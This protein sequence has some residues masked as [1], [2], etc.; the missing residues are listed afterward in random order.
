M[1]YKDWRTWWKA[2]EPIIREAL[3]D[4]GYPVDADKLLPPPNKPET[5]VC[6]KSRVWFLS[7]RTRHGDELSF[8]AKCDE[9]DRFREEWKA[10]EEL[11]D[12][13]SPIEA[14]LPVSGNKPKHNVIVYQ[15]VAEQVLTG[16]VWTLKRLLKEQLA[17]NLDNC[18]QA[19]EDTL[20]P[21]RLF[22]TSEP[23]SARL[24]DHLGRG[25]W[26]AIF[27]AVQ[28]KLKQVENRANPQWLSGFQRSLPDP[29][30][31]APDFLN[32]RLGRV[33]HSRI[34]GDLNLTN[35]LI[36]LN[37]WFGPEKVFLIDLANSQRDAVTALD[38]ARLECEFWHEIFAQLGGE[39]ISVAER[40]NV[41]VAIR[42]CLDGRTCTLESSLPKAG[43]N[44]L[45]WVKKIR[46]EAYRT[47][48]GNQPDY[49]MADYMTALYLTHLRCL[50]FE[51][52]QESE[53]KQRIATLGAALALEYLLAL[54]KGGNP[55]IPVAS[56][57][58][59]ILTY[60]ED[61]IYIPQREWNANSCPPG[62]LLQ[63]NYVIVPFHG[64]EKAL[65]DLTVWAQSVSPISVRLYTG[66][67]GIGKTRLAIEICK[68]L[69]TMGY[70]AGFLRHIKKDLLI[71]TFPNNQNL[72]FVIDYAESNR[73]IVIQILAMLGSMGRD[74]VRIMLLARSAGQWWKNLRAE[75]DGVGD[76]IAS[77]A[78]Q[79]IPL[80]PLALTADEC[81]ASYWMA[82]KAFAEK[83]GQSLPK[84]EPDFNENYFEL[85]LLLHMRALAA[86][87]GV[88]V[89]GEDGI[90][91]YVLNRERRFWKKLLLDK[92][93]N[94]VLHQGLER[95]MAM[96]TLGGGVENKRE[97]LD[98]L[99]RIP[100]FA[101]EKRSVL[102]AV[103]EL[104]HASYPG[105]K[106]IE[107]I[108]P[109]LLGEHLFSTAL[110]DDA[111]E[112]FDLMLGEKGKN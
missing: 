28:N 25:T 99:R 62:A 13:K 87:E 11:R 60:N 5:G 93:L 20:K 34:H 22:Y 112:I 16:H 9:P 38:L 105:E 6:G 97:A 31:H 24:T 43:Q 80:K 98:V 82:A 18:L 71:Q 76:L 65:D 81:R 48:A 47:L 91:E 44:V 69:S 77:P 41:F 83:L 56:V 32:E 45:S 14:M 70:C 89:E 86:V 39:R 101:D 26:T 2:D 53:M 63:A 50:A 88:I 52:V 64:R 17:D 55:L 95:A 100:F 54:R 111:G 84:E 94:P 4:M 106:W 78:T 12:L 36:G 59:P 67:G 37:G 58:S 85:V 110:K 19:L 21:L 103:A 61:E 102:E 51:S 7:M 68:R 46:E 96:F 35:V 23:G 10:I 1:E 57:T 8:I 79:W 30:R 74:C 3:I 49:H 73:D 33:L 42:D 27:P 75:S 66:R 109:D 15:N 107:P 92:E 72:F 29:F 90:L 104:L 40:A 108:Q